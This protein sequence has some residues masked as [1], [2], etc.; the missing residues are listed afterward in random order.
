MASQTRHR[1]RTPVVSPHTLK[2]EAAWGDARARTT[3]SANPYY[4][5][6]LPA[7]SAFSGYRQLF[8]GDQMYKVER[9]LIRIIYVIPA[10]CMDNDQF[11]HAK[12]PELLEPGTV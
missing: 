9:I 6:T 4:R 3:H 7:R 11:V 10:F 5:E 1:N 8:V 2:F 12:L